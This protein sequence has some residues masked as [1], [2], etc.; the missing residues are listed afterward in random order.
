MDIFYEL[1]EDAKKRLRKIRIPK[2]IRLDINKMVDKHLRLLGSEEE[3]IISNVREKAE[4]IKTLYSLYVLSK[5]IN[6]RMEKQKSVDKQKRKKIRM[7]I[8]RFGKIVTAFAKHRRKKG[9][10]KTPKQN[11]R[12]NEEQKRGNAKSTIS[13]ASN[14]SLG[15]QDELSTKQKQNND[16]ERM[17]EPMVKPQV[18]IVKDPLM[19]EIYDQLI[20]GFKAQKGKLGQANGS[21]FIKFLK[22]SGY[23]EGKG[24][25][26]DK[27][28]P[29]LF[30][31][32]SA[33]EFRQGGHSKKIQITE[34]FLKQIIGNLTPEEEN[35]LNALIVLTIGLHKT[36]KQRLRLSTATIHGLEEMGVMSRELRDSIM[37]KKR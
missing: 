20:K 9:T 18:V 13:R 4:K 23:V 16:E 11:R 12:Q 36:T 28:I 22:N 37:E 29:T 2:E 21:V 8:K 25:R 17:A 15:G 10:N 26:H 3:C 30:K 34:S 32:E 24:S 5:R 19:K 33:P 14:G 1:D 27:F 35:I 31:G 7:L 6:E